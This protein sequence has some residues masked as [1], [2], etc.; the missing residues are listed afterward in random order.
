LA[1]KRVGGG[2]VL[3]R[4]WYLGLSFCPREGVKWK[5]QGE[6]K[7]GS[8]GS[9]NHTVFIQTY[10]E[11][12]ILVG[13]PWFSPSPLKIIVPPP[14]QIINPTN[15]F[16]YH[17]ALLRMFYYFISHAFYKRFSLR[18]SVTFPPFSSP[19]SS[20]AFPYTIGIYMYMFGCTYNDHPNFTT[21]TSVA[22][23]I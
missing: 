16:D 21:D 15:H 4:Q 6:D 17:F 1:P 8:K 11:V 7:G 3:R 5:G 20:P 2:R 13:K 9:M 12:N 19:F 10:I 23:K 14:P 22:P 18:I